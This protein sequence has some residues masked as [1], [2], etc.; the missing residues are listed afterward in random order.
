[1]NERPADDHFYMRAWESPAVVLPGGLLKH[2]RHLGIQ[3]DEMMLIIQLLAFRQ[4]E[5]N[6]FPTFDQLAER[7]ACDRHEVMQ[8]IQRLVQ[9]GVLQ[10]AQFQDP[11]SGMTTET[12]Q[13]EPLFHK[14]QAF[15]RG[16]PAVAPTPPGQKSLFTVFEEEFGRP[17]SPME[18]ELIQTWLDREG[19]SE[20]LIIA[21]LKEAVLS[22]KR[23]FRYIDRILYEWQRNGIQTPQEAQMHVMRFRERQ[24]R[25]SGPVNFTFYNWLEEEPSG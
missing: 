16:Q 23:S 21:A 13:L 3:D 25:K 15:E 5:Q 7:L 17:L 4:L 9:K 8:R 1:M 24:Q 2:Y 11:V 6:R 20:E 12:Y 22:G 18:Y 14:W 10:I 19:C